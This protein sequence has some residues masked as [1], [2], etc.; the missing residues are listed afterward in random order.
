VADHL[1]VRIHRPMGPR[2]AGAYAQCR[3]LFS[4]AGMLHKLWGGPPGPRGS[5]RTRRSPEESI[6]CRPSGPARG[7]AADQG[8]RPTTS[9]D[10][11][12]REKLAALRTSAPYDIAA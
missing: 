1:H 4:S 7:P 8:V 5:P 12:F 2:G 9:A 11:Q 6:S 10:V 3:K